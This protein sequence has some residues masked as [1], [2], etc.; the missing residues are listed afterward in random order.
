LTAL[1]DVE[2]IGVHV[3]D[4]PEYTGNGTPSGDNNGE[5]SGETSSG[6]SSGN[7]NGTQIAT[8]NSNTYEDEENTPVTFQEAGL[9][10][11]PEEEGGN[12][13]PENTAYTYRGDIVLVPQESSET[14]QTNE[15]NTQ[16]PQNSTEI[17]NIALFSDVRSEWNEIQSGNVGV[18][19]HNLNRKMKAA[20]SAIVS[21]QTST[22]EENTEEPNGISLFND[23]YGIA[24]LSDPPEKETIDLKD[25]SVHFY[26]ENGVLLFS[27]G[28]DASTQTLQVW[29]VKDNTVTIIGE[30]AD[31]SDQI[32]VSSGV[33]GITINLQDVTMKISDTG[34]SPIKIEKNT[35]VTLKIQDSNTSP[36]SSVSATLVG[37]TSAPAID[38]N[39]NATL[40]ITGTSKL[41]LW[42]GSGA[43]AISSTSK[44]LLGGRLQVSG[45]V[46][47]QAY[48]SSP[49]G[50]SGAIYAQY[51]TTDGTNR[52]I[53]GQVKNYTTYVT[54]DNGYGK[55]PKGI[56]IENIKYQTSSGGDRYFLEIPVQTT[57]TRFAVT[58]TPASAQY[59]AYYAEN[60][61]STIKDMFETS[62]NGQAITI[63]SSSFRSEL[64]AVSDTTK[65]EAERTHIFDLTT[66]TQVFLTDLAPSKIRYK[67]YL[68]GN[69]GYYQGKNDYLEI[70]A[71][72]G[73]KLTSE[74]R[75]K[76][77]SWKK[78]S[79]EDGPS[80]TTTG[81]FT[82]TYTE[83]DYT[84]VAWYFIQGSRDENYKWLDNVPIYQSMTL[85][86]TW[87]TDWNK[88]VFMDSTGKKVLE[89]DGGV[90]YIK[91]GFS[92]DSWESYTGKTIFPPLNNDTTVPSSTWRVFE[93]KAI[94]DMSDSVYGD[95]NL[96]YTLLSRVKLTFTTVDADN[97]KGM[98]PNTV[99]VESAT[100][101]VYTPPVRGDGKIYTFGGWR[102]TLNGKK[103]K[104]DDK[105][106]VIP[107]VTELKFE[108]IWYL[109]TTTIY[110]AEDADAGEDCTIADLAVDYGQTI[111]EAIVTY[112][113]LN[114]TNIQLRATKEARK[115]NYT[116]YTFVGWYTDKTYTTEFA[117]NTPVESEVDKIYLYP[118]FRQNTCYVFFEPGNA[119]AVQTTEGV[120]YLKADY[121][122]SL[123]DEGLEEKA[124]TIYTLTGHSV[125]SWQVTST[126]NIKTWDTTTVMTEDVTVK[127]VW[128]KNKYTVTYTVSESS[129]EPKVTTGQQTLGEGIFYGD[130]VPSIGYPTE[131]QKAAYPGHTFQGWYTAEDGQ[132]EKW[133]FKG[134]DGA[135][136]IEDN[137]ELFA[138]WTWDEYTVSFYT[139][140]NDTNTVP[141]SISGVH[142]GETLTKPYYAG[143]RNHYTFL[144][145]WGTK[146]EDG[147]L[148]KWD[149]DIDTVKG[150]MTLYPLWEGEPIDIMLHVFLEEENV[151]SFEEHT[152]LLNSKTYR[153]GDKLSVTD[154]KPADFQYVADRV[155]YTLNGWYLSDY[156][157]DMWDYDNSIAEPAD[158]AWNATQTRLQ[159]DLYAYWTWNTYTVTFITYEGDTSGPA[160]QEVKH[161]LGITKP[162]NPTRAHYEFGGWYTTAEFTDGTEWNFD[163][164]NT[165]VVT[166]EVILYAKWIPHVYLLSFNTNGGTELS[167]VEVTYGTYVPTSALNTTKTGYVVEGWYRDEAL[168]VKFSP[169]TE[170]VDGNMT[171][172]ANWELKRYTVRFHYRA[173]EDSLEEELVTQYQTYQAGMR[174][175]APTKTKANMTLS[176]WYSDPSYQ[177]RW[178]FKRDTVQ[179]DTDLYAYWT[180]TKYPLHFDTDGGASLA[181]LNLAWG[182]LVESMQTTPEK[183]GH[184]FTGWYAD[185]ACTVRLFDETGTKGDDDED[186]VILEETTIYAG[187]KVNYYTVTFDVNGG[188]GSVE[189]QYIPYGSLIDEPAVKPTRTGYIF[190]GWAVTSVS[191]T[192]SNTKNNSNNS[193]KSSSAIANEQIQA[194]LFENVRSTQLLASASTSIQLRSAEVMLLAAIEDF[195]EEN[196]AW[197]F[198]ND[199]LK[200]NTTMTALWYD[201]TQDTT[202]S[203]NNASTV[204]AA[205]ANAGNATGT[206]TVEATNALA[207]AAQALKSALTGDNAPWTYTILSVILAAIAAVWA[208]FLRMNWKK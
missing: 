161:G 52:L 49:T 36:A 101:P 56:L 137:I 183:E 50:T 35:E 139:F 38:L 175:V 4:P 2:A 42:S 53:Q 75:V 106:D 25:G 201:P 162:T 177:T 114:A 92:I 123:K 17:T 141:E 40:Y 79:T 185:K 46:V 203:T 107:N 199:T 163:N 31:K 105:N 58:T 57:Y 186:L 166:G 23:D 118:K 90:A 160:P 168:T 104:W 190:A 81:E 33:T 151:P 55:T 181:D 34:V 167:P 117:T 85:Y 202:N 45:S 74:D 29:K 171:I 142:Y 26:V 111:E 102:V 97:V 169:T 143:V 153:Y 192:D 12:N 128:A 207:S 136:K 39:T 112:N 3:G 80:N 157:T 109:N 69:G 158:D 127:V 83:R 62:N 91:S 155:G 134:E 122:F 125:A 110:F 18:Q 67:I 24:L 13:L 149:F 98:P 115:L 48:S 100:I 15:T 96:Y 208:M 99:G 156:F 8:E 116:E 204:D 154:L 87:Q 146:N 71:S 77:N 180:Y 103:V 135:M 70:Q 131:E 51:M 178:V 78:E 196:N 82:G 148:T 16:E 47:V 44:E 72:Y 59:V 65:S 189:S 63:E 108:A 188:K 132:G 21:E 37:G 173:S 61:G 130:A 88:I 95:L 76:I 94:W 120:N 43:C 144:D 133:I 197:D 126:G 145:A 205:T 121:G 22:T 66:S 176:D 89:S 206:G 195:Q 129:G 19:Q 9:E 152:F 5:T 200:G 187:W 68:Y 191:T 165:N 93:T 14:T 147:T 174:V 32:L 54:S 113:K 64:L 138:Y 179:D 73:Q 182:T 27:Q 20:R 159:F 60:S 124:R 170:F 6:D 86:L 41:A 10:E 193:T 184:T 172:Y 84:P 28:I 1:Q 140:E 150:N 11:E 194:Q 7:T 119:N 164:P 30:Q 198:A